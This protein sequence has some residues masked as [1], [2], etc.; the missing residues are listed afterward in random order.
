MLYYFFIFFCQTKQRLGCHY[1]FCSGAFKTTSSLYLSAEQFPEEKE[2]VHVLFL[3]HAALGIC[4]YVRKGFVMNN[5]CHLS[6]IIHM[7]VKQKLEYALIWNDSIKLDPWRFL[8][9]CCLH[10]FFCH[11][12]RSNLFS[13]K[14]NWTRSPY[15]LV[16]T[17]R[18]FY[19]PTATLKNETRLHM[20]HRMVWELLCTFSS[21]L[22]D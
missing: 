10:F 9:T 12:S 14:C 18:S 6:S 11:L 19:L 21:V 5:I 16:Q 13:P 22:R 7:K 15:I 17:Q 1:V 3:T 8:T 4:G 2:N 20:V